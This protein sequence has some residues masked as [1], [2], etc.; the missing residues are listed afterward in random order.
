MEGGVRKASNQRMAPIIGKFWLPAAAVMICIAPAVESLRGGGGG[1]RELA[2]SIKPEGAVACL[3]QDQCDTR[4]AK[5]GFRDDVYYV[6]DYETKGC[7]SKNG[8]AY[9]GTGGTVEAMAKESLAGVRTRIW[10]G[11]LDTDQPTDQP[12]ISP[13]TTIAFSSKPT[14]SPIPT[15][16]AP[17]AE[18]TADDSN[19]TSQA[20]ETTSL[21]ETTTSTEAP[22]TAAVVKSPSS[23]TETPTPTMVPSSEVILIVE[24]SDSQTKSPVTSEP[25]VE[26]S[27]SP[28]KSPS[29]NPSESPITSQPSNAKSTTLPENTSLESSVAPV[30]SFTTESTDLEESFESE[31]IPPATESESLDGSTDLQPFDLALFT[32]LFTSE[33]DTNELSDIIANHLL[34]AFQ[35]ESPDSNIARVSVTLEDSPISTLKRSLQDGI[36]G[37]ALKDKKFAYQVKGEVSYS[38]PEAPT[39][40]SISSATKASFDGQAGDAFLVSLQN[41]E[42]PGLQST[43]SYEVDLTEVE[44]NEVDS[45]EVESNEVDSTEV[46]SNEVDSTEVESNEVDLTEVEYDQVP[47]ES[48][49]PVAEEEEKLIENHV[50]YIVIG[51]F[52][53]CF[54]LIGMYILKTRRGRKQLERAESMRAAEAED[55]DRSGEVTLPRYIEVD[56]E[57]KRRR[58]QGSAITQCTEVAPDFTMCSV[59]DP[60]QN[61]VVG[62]SSNA[63]SSVAQM[64]QTSAV[65]DQFSKS[66]L[67]GQSL[68]SQSISIYKRFNQQD[69]NTI[70]ET[71]GVNEPLPRH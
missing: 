27:Q 61:S 35:D 25:S 4:R 50:L 21:L 54:V 71:R 68:T 46:E 70:S 42:D 62:N 14:P 60:M 51:I 29:S 23:S 12:S 1:R 6:G 15:E 48:L 43:K 7:F 59:T 47:V 16:L 9:F 44:S 10:C 40:E 57:T 32:D 45:T 41:A 36:N 63:S 64:S 5:Q 28:T 20:K 56:S 37:F 3:T 13:P 8:R 58:A 11:L 26:P 67:S 69:L 55:D 24:P 19:D 38:G 17:D 65:S 34:V 18:T 30:N 53:V 66:T 22:E 33:L 52:S 31:A 49:L 39:P 2:Q